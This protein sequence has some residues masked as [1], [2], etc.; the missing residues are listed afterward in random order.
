MSLA[1]SLRTASSRVRVTMNGGGL[2][3]HRGRLCLLALAVLLLEV[4]PLGDRWPQAARASS[5]RTATAVSLSRNAT[6]IDL[7]GYW[8]VNGQW[9]YDAPDFD[10]AIKFTQHEHVVHA[11]WLNPDC[12][13][14]VVPP[15]AIRGRLDG[16]N[17]T[18][19]LAFCMHIPE[20]CDWRDLFHNSCRSPKTDGFISTI[21]GCTLPRSVIIKT[22]AVSSS[23]SG[24]MIIGTVPF[25]QLYA[26][27][28]VMLYGEYPF[29][30]TRIPPGEV[31]HAVSPTRQG[32]RGGQVTVGSGLSHP[33]GVA[34]D[35]AGNVFIA[36]S[37]NSRVV[38]VASSGAQTTVASRLP[39]APLGVAVDCTGN[40][41]ILTSDLS[42]NI[43]VVKVAPGGAQTTVVSG[44]SF[45]TQLA[46]DHS[47]NVYLPDFGDVPDQVVKLAPNGAQTAVGSGL[48]TP[49]GA[50]V[51]RAGNVFIA[52]TYNNRVVKVAPSGAQTT[53]AAG[54]Q[55]P[56]SV[57]VD[58]A[59]NV[60]TTD[61]DNVVK[62]T[63]SGVKTTVGA[64]VHWVPRCVAMDRAGN[65]YVA[66]DPGS[67]VVK[68]LGAGAPTTAR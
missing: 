60:F 63:P 56:Q 46:V 50:A 26:N 23:P 8:Y 2:S 30:L 55:R 3:G 68:V 65:L 66:D 41:F 48:N 67:R 1:G 39:G 35:S 29:T 31:P 16:A 33:G 64:G 14:G 45:G 25:P 15:D 44:Q 38:K 42:G 10:R 9:N 4:V 6:S 59:G 57:A 52:D 61:G 40:V 22:A 36:D 53:V 11:V 47:G 24:V 13:P 54:L 27:C 17:L 32:S 12:G 58:G 49:R 37:D 51:D 21:H 5:E 62:V 34:V 19:T 28:S 7:S 43:Q 20:S 18:G